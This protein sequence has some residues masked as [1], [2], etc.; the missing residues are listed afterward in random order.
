MVGDYVYNYTAASGGTNITTF[1][2]S[3][4]LTFTYKDSQIT[5]LKES[6]L[7]VYY[8]DAVNSQWVA[9]STYTVNLL[10]NTITVTTNHFTYFAIFGE[11]ETAGATSTSTTPVAETTPSKPISQMTVEELKAEVVRIMALILNQKCF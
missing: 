3:V 10:N 7:Q 1:S 5:G 4:T 8:W 9:M 11:A 2:Q 6:T